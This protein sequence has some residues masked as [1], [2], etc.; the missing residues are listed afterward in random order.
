MVPTVAA[1]Q[2]SRSDCIC[3]MSP[4]RTIILLNLWY[5]CNCVDWCYVL[6]STSPSLPL[7]P[8]LCSSEN[9]KC[10]HN[11]LYQFTLNIFTA[12]KYFANSYT[13][14]PSCLILVVLRLTGSTYISGRVRF[15]Q[16]S[17]A[18]CMLSLQSGSLLL[19]LF[20]YFCSFGGIGK[21]ERGIG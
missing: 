15:V 13:S 6:N 1:V 4:K 17:A 10:N 7:P 8:S 3:A 20:I 9:P 5:S 18:L 21:R 14:R 11:Q 16:L 2:N 12:N 19:L